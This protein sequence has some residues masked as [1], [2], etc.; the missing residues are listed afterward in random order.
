MSAPYLGDFDTGVIVRTMWSTYGA[1]GASITR[2]TNGT[3]SVYKDNSVT[4]S[5]DGITDTEDF[6]ALTGIHALN[7]DLSSNGSFYSAGA[8]FTVVL[9]AATIDG[10]VVN[11]VLAHFSIRNRYNVPSDLGTTAKAAVNAEV[12]DVLNTDTF[13]EPGQEAPGATITLAKK[14]SYLYK[15]FRNRM[16]QDAT[17]QK[18]YAD[19]T[20]TVDQKATV[21]D[22]GTVFD[23]GELGTGP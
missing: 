18:L 20:T 17:T 8:N 14:I 9:S 2:A 21:S 4:Q 19:D 10:Q 12:L 15:A 7:V 3:I 23:R 5:T 22:N 16:T 11:A 6:D 1:N 13:A